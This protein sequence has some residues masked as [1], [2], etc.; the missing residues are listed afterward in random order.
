MLDGPKESEILEELNL[1]RDDFIEWVL[2]STSED[3]EFKVYK[4][5]HYI[6]VGIDKTPFSSVM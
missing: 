6:M 5:K 1:C 4:T 2:K 3:S